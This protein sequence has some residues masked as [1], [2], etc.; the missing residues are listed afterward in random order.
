MSKIT[1]QPLG[2]M[3]YVIVGMQNTQKKPPVLSSQMVT[4]LPECLEALGCGTEWEEEVGDRG[5]WFLGVS[6]FWLHSCH[7]L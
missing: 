5:P 4:L 7:A 6:C 1:N 2:Q 3:A